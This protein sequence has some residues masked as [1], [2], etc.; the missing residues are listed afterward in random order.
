[1]WHYSHAPDQLTLYPVWSP[2]SGQDIGVNLFIVDATQGGGTG[3][4]EGDVNCN[5]EEVVFTYCLDCADGAE[6]AVIG[7]EGTTFAFSTVEHPGTGQKDDGGEGNPLTTNVFLELKDL[8]E[9]YHTLTLSAYIIKPASTSCA[10]LAALDGNAE[11]INPMTFYFFVFT[12]KP[13]TRVGSVFPQYITDSSS[14]IP[15]APD[16]LVWG[17]WKPGVRTVCGPLIHGR[18]WVHTASL[19]QSKAS[20]WDRQSPALCSRVAMVITLRFA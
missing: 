18:V 3:D 7:G 14:T 1:M 15:S 10:A 16:C 13:E 2:P 6:P 12:E 9:G 19:P 11:V 5:S 8:T 4:F 20:R 17:A